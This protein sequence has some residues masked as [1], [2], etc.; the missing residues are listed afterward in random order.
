[1]KKSTTAVVALGAGLLI[2]VGVPLAANAH[3]TVSPNAAEAGGYSLITVKVPNE[4]A[5]ASTVSVSVALPADTPFTSVSYVPVAGWTAE[6]TRST[7]PSPVKVGENE[8]TDAV[9]QVTWTAQP[10]V[11]IGQGELQLFPL[12]LGPVPNTGSLTLAATQTYSDGTVV[13]WS[14]EGE[15]A[16]H[17]APVLYVNDAPAADHHGTG[18]SVDVAQ[19]LR[20]EDE[21]DVLARVLGIVGLALGAVAAVISIVALRRITAGGK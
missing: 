5:T 9:T 15:G 17:P 16:E 3:V 2:A 10:G 14:E 1:M 20:A 11:G 4:S 12:S 21:S 18:D 13:E 6:L 8:I 7:L 19:E